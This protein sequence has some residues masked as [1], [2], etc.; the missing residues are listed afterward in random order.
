M[1]F[2]FIFSMEPFGFQT[3]FCIWNHLNVI[4]ILEPFECH[5]NGH[6]NGSILKINTD[7][8]MVPY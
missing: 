3:D 6:P 8:Q 7:I 1:I 2:V 4:Q 5:S